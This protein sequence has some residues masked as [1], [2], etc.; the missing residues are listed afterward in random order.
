MTVLR[1]SWGG[2]CDGGLR[3][4]DGAC[5]L[6]AHQ[7]RPDGQ[8]HSVPLLANECLPP[9][10]HHSITN[11][12]GLCSPVAVGNSGHRATHSSFEGDVAQ[13]D[14]VNAGM[15]GHDPVY[16][17]AGLGSAQGID[18]ERADQPPLDGCAPLETSSPIFHRTAPIC[19]GPAHALLV[20][21]KSA[22]HI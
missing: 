3:F 16:E 7:G 1:E 10:I 17:S 15:D 22:R 20:W 14:I 5:D 21:L 11:T 2:D 4:D 18:P 13:G 6:D 9:P 12:N 8:F 19:S